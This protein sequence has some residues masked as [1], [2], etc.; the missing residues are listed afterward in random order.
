MKKIL[1]SGS[2]AYDMIMQFDGE[3]KDL[4]LPDQ[5]DQLNV[6]FNISTMEKRN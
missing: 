2:I 6:C 3:F 5:I 4:I 1:V